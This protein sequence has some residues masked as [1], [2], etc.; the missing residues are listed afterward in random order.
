MSRFMIQT[1]LPISPFH[2]LAALVFSVITYLFIESKRAKLDHIPGPWL[3]KY[4]NAWR[5]YQAW[6]FN[7]Y[8]DLSNYQINLI[9]RYG[10]VV[11]IGPNIVLCFDPEAISTI[12]GVK[13]RL[14]KV[15]FL[16]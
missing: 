7:H 14:D 16:D 4:T 11:R 8:K 3:A 10:D 15:S 9:C 13:E 12:Y 1:F 6:R 2:L 5:C